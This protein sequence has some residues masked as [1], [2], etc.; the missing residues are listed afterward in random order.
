LLTDVR[1]RMFPES[2]I[3]TAEDVLKRCRHKNIMLATAESCTGGLV[4][5][6]LTEIPGASSVF[7]RGFVTYSNQAKETLLGVAKEMIIQY[8]AVSEQVAATMAAGALANSKA[9]VSIAITGIAGPEG[10]TVAKPVGLVYIAVAYANGESWVEEFHFKGD[11]SQIRL[12]AVE[13]G[14]ELVQKVIIVI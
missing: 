9:N 10:G 1:N 12:A 14:L 8:G 5:A 7:E 6:L 2:L 11:R 4:S 13:K 3:T